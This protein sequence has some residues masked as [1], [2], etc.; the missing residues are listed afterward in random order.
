MCIRDRSN[1]EAKKTE[2]KKIISEN[3]D[4]IKKKLETKSQEKVKTTLAKIYT[5]LDAKIERLTDVDTKIL[6][7]I[8][9]STTKGVDMTASKAQY[10]IAKKALDKAITDIAATKAVSIDQTSVQTSKEAIRALVKT[11]EDSIKAAGAEYRRII[12]LIL[13]G[14]STNNVE[15]GNSSNVINQ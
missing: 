14:Q 7:K 12:P 11:A 9:D 2:V 4:V 15:G 10:T 5:N 3:K 1:I 13:P 8:D 6:A